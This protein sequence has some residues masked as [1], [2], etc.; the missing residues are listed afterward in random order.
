MSGPR[1][2]VDTAETVQVNLRKIIN[3]LDI[4]PSD[5]VDRIAPDA[6]GVRQQ[7]TEKP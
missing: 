6:P 1:L 2:V 5:R 7:K 3:A 4:V